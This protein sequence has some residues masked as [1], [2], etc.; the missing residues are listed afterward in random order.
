MGN[1]ASRPGGK[2]TS[3]IPTLKP[4]DLQRLSY[5]NCKSFFRSF[6]R[7]NFITQFINCLHLRFSIPYFSDNPEELQALYL[8]FMSMKSPDNADIPSLS[9]EWVANFCLLFLLG[10]SDPYSRCREFQNAL[11]FTKDRSSKFV[12]RVFYLMD[13]DKDGALWVYADYN[14]G[15]ISSHLPFSCR[16]FEEFLEGVSIFAPTSTDK[17]YR[18]MCTRRI[19]C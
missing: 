18:C 17:K 10:S 11:G 12:E 6:V 1:K 3:S 7:N 2:L 4:K 19:T 9:I 8:Q 13:G 15:L 16:I 5:T 14:S